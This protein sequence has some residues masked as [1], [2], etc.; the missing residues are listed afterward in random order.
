MVWIRHRGGPN[1][2]PLPVPEERTYSDIRATIADEKGDEWEMRPGRLAPRPL[3][4]NPLNSISSWNFPSYP[5]RGRVL[6]FRIYVRNSSDQWDTLAE[7]K[8]P[9]PTPGPHPVWKPMTLPMTLA[10]GDLEVSLVD[11]VSGKRALRYLPKDQRPF[12]TTRFR[13]K[14]NS[15]PTEAWLPDLMDATDATGN[16]ADFGVIDYGI[17]NAI[18]SYDAQGTSMSPSEVWRLRM[19]FRR[20]NDSGPDEMRYF[21]FFAQPIVQ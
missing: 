21:E 7:F 14:Q 18:I 5:R 13:V 19:R 8:M 12:T 20:E 11:L 16:E 17:T 15:E 3:S 10:N 1:A 2:P 9:N 4:Q 6:K